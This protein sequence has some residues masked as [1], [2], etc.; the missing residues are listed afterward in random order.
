MVGYRDI[1]QL[2]TSHN[3]FSA[4][5]A[6][7]FDWECEMSKKA[8]LI[9]VCFIVLLVVAVV[10]KMLD[11]YHTQF[12]YEPSLDQAVFGAF[13][14]YVGGLLNPLIGLLTIMLLAW[15]LYQASVGIAILQTQIRDADKNHKEQMKLLKSERDLQSAYTFLQYYTKLREDRLQAKYSTE[16][17]D[18]VILY[19]NDYL[20]SELEK[21]IY[22]QKEMGRRIRN[23]L[24]LW[25]AKSIPH[26]INEICLNVNLEDRYAS[27]E[28]IGPN[29]P[30]RGYWAEMYPSENSVGLDNLPDEWLFTKL[31]HYHS[32]ACRDIA[33]ALGP[34][35]KT[36][37][38]V[39]QPH[40]N[41]FQNLEDL[42]AA[43][44]AQ[45]KK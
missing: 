22:R 12:G 11:V 10:I 39:M 20:N 44:A 30:V 45:E 16:Q 21:L 24:L 28:V 37:G 6:A 29:E 40:R 18:K 38:A 26:G 31:S 25:T 17:E 36:A 43:R 7:Q 4:E 5:L 32:L 1:K 15:S 8:F 23:T 34:N 14:D 13:G 19:L 2:L 42:Q 3:K 27:F 41:I 35:G 9:G 33:E